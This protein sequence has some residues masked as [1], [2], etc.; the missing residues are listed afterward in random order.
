MKNWLITGCSSGIGKSIAKAVLEGG[1]NA[2]VTARSIGKLDDLVREYPDRCMAVYLDVT[3]KESIDTAVEQACERFET[4]DVLVNNAGYGYRS[5]I[6]EGETDRVDALFNTNL[7][8]PIELIKKVLPLMRSRKSGAI[9][10]ISSIAAVKSGM[11]SG[12]YAASKAALELITDALAQEIM[13]L[14]IKVMLVEPGAFRTNFY[15]TSLQGTK[16]KIDDYAETA[17]RTRKENLIDRH[18]QPGNPDKAGQVIMEVINREDYPYCLLLGSD[19]VRRVTHQLSKRI[20]E[21][22]K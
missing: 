5:S 7:F 8:G 10:N 15:D 6:E 18:D 22:E 11:G 12:Y 17:G 4:I 16:N 13:P 3:V 9:V 1:D 21:A 20:K 19:A 2:I 14:G